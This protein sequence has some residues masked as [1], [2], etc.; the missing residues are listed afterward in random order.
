MLYIQAHPDQLDQ[1]CDVD[2]A[3]EELRERW[4]A[5]SEQLDQQQ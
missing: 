1:C 3:I 4:Q 2:V 5:V